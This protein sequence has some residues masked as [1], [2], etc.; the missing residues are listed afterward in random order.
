MICLSAKISPLHFVIFGF[1]LENPLLPES[2]VLSPQK[3]LRFQRLTIDGAKCELGG[4]F[5]KVVQIELWVFLEKK[6]QR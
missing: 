1:F 4:I 5:K 3:N 6:F 2:S